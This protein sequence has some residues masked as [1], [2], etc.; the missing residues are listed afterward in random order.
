MSQ[1]DF[2]MGLLDQRN[3]AV[4]FYLKG[5]LVHRKYCKVEVIHNVTSSEVQSIIRFPMDKEIICDEVKAFISEHL[6]FHENFEKPRRMYMNGELEINDFLNIPV[7]TYAKAP[8]IKKEI[9]NLLKK[10]NGK[11]VC[12]NDEILFIDNTSKTKNIEKLSWN[13][14]L[15]L[16]TL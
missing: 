8:A 3:V 9:K 6:V 1:A 10:Y 12:K 15:S 14:E 5:E 4:L 11:I 16:E 2:F 13:N 7:K